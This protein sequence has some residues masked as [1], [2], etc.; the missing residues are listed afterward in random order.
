M[1]DFTYAFDVAE[2]LCQQLSEDHDIQEADNALQERYNIDLDDFAAILTDLLPLIDVGTSS[3]TGK[4]YK[5]F[6]KG[7]RFLAKVEIE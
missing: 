3:L 7:G 4:R 1:T 2:A 6:A 5:G